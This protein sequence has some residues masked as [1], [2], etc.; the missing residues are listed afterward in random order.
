VLG[1][2]AIHW[3]YLRKQLLLEVLPVEEHCCTA[4][5]RGHHG[6]RGG[7]LWLAGLLGTK[8]CSPSLLVVLLDY[9]EDC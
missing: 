4:M 3:S 5:S 7:G 6:R 2:V 9:T 8:S 1:A